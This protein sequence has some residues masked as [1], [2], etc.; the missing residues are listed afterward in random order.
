MATSGG[1]FDMVC[2]L[3]NVYLQV[4]D[5]GKVFPQS[6]FFCTPKKNRTVT[7]LLLFIRTEFE[8]FSNIAMK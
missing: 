1:G 6:G 2:I 4:S 5:I 8:V 3:R 7:Q